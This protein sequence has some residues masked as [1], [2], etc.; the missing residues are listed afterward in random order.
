MQLIGTRWRLCG[1]DMWGV[2]DVRILTR[3]VD[4]ACGFM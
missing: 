3:T 1:C 2:F 4:N